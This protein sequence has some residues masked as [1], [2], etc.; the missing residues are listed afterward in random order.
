MS[1]QAKEFRG[2]PVVAIIGGGFTGAA[3]A[4][5]LLDGRRLPH[6]ARL[7]IVEPR[8]EIGRGLAYGTQDPAHRINV[9]AGKMTLLPEVS[10][11]FVGYAEYAGLQHADPRLVGRDGLPYPQRSAFGDYVVARVRPFIANGRLEHW[12]TKIRSVEKTPDGYCLLGADGAKLHVDL[13]IIAVS[14]PAPA[15]PANLRAFASDPKFVA[16]VTSGHSLTP[17]ARDDSVLIV[18]NGLT[19]ADVIASLALNGHRG[20]ITAISR[21][22]LRSRGHGPAG[23]AAYGDLLT[24]R[25]ATASGL[26]HQVRRLVREAEAQ[27]LTWHSVL[28]AV[29]AQ[30]QAIWQ[31]LPVRERARIARHV[32]P[33]WDVHRFRIAPQVEDVVDQATAEGRLRVL[34][35]S[36][37]SAHK[38]ETGYEVGLRKRFQREVQTVAVDSIVVTTGPAHGGILESQDFLRALKAE[39]L[40]KA[41]PT[42]LGIAVDQESHAL[43]AKDESLPDLLIAGPLARGTFGELMGLPQV[44]EHAVFVADRIAALVAA[45]IAPAASLSKAS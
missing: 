25:A 2:R 31:G 1:V 32:R 26:L 42:G 39:G 16:D 10:E 17:I 45:R 35:A 38:T 34:A 27:G 12:Q 40:L 11:D 36:I 15:V 24:D 44:T 41:C 21:R 37:V 22:G 30:G 19:S 5:H 13:L 9:P 28:D 8:D 33:F 29:R 14:H 6:D 23:Q 18:G 3:V 4:F 7:L 20:P 43:S